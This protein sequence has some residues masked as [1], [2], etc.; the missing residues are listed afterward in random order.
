MVISVEQITTKSMVV[1]F[2]DDEYDDILLGKTQYIVKDGKLE[3]TDGICL[4][5][6]R[7]AFYQIPQKKVKK[8]K[9]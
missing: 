7:K 5:E 8:E 1:E 9:K 3:T 4:V 6:E 2:S